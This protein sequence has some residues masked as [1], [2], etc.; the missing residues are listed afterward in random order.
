MAIC[1]GRSEFEISARIKHEVVSYVESCLDPSCNRMELTIKAPSKTFLLDLQKAG[2]LFA[3]DYLEQIG[4]QEPVRILQGR[5]A[6]EIPGFDC[7]YESINPAVLGAISVCSRGIEGSFST[8]EGTFMLHFD[9][10]LAETCIYKSSDIPPQSTQYMTK[11]LRQRLDESL[12]GWQAKLPDRSIEELSARSLSYRQERFIELLVVIDRE[13]YEIYF[14]KSMDKVRAFVKGYVLTANQLYRQDPE[15]Q[16]SIVLIGLVVWTE[17][18]PIL[19]DRTGR[20]K[21]KFCDHGQRLDD[22]I[23]FNVKHLYPKFLQDTVVVFTGKRFPGSDGTLGIT[24]M[25]VTCNAPELAVHSVL[26]RKTDRLTYLTAIHEM[27]HNLGFEDNV[28]SPRQLQTCPSD[29]AK[30]C[31]GGCAGAGRDGCIMNAC[32]NDEVGAIYWDDCTKIIVKMRSEAGK[33]WCLYNRPISNMKKDNEFISYCGNGIVEYG[34]T[35]D[36]TPK[37]SEC[38]RCCEGCQLK[39]GSQCSSGPCCNT[40]GTQCLLK[41][42]GEPCKFSDDRC[43]S[44]ETSCTGHSEQCP[45]ELS[46]EVKDCSDDGSKLCYKGS[47]ISKCPENCFGQGDCVGTM[48]DGYTCECHLMYY[49]A[50]CQIRQDLSTHV[51]FGVV[52]GICAFFITLIIFRLVELSRAGWKYQKIREE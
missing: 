30:H 6:S 43:A 34:E 24:H 8:I 1:F 17:G 19:F 12:A 44:N 41:L 35:C 15:I 26:L 38:L 2:N 45:D 14:K 49:G 18:D 31:Y 7:F 42:A 9:D 36:C 51:A 10:E 21:D 28:F 16:F 47:C 32:L 52:L 37:D 29:A 11:E 4:N 20:C 39:E 48:K 50:L 5:S 46:L 22:L 3:D 40:A 13:G 23:N 25:G 33:Y 27:G